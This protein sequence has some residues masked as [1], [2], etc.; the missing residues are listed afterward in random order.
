LGVP[1]AMV[2]PSTLKVYATGSG[3]ADKDA[4]LKA[5]RGMWPD[6]DIED[7]NSADAL[8][9][10]AMGARYLGH[11]CDDVPAERWASLDGAEWPDL[12]S[13]DGPMLTVVAS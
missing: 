13:D 1:V 5:A 12:Y 7:D 9:L 3:A 2:P 8:L 11:P 10:A 6:V 4:M